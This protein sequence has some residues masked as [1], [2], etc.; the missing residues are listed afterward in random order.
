MIS[1]IENLFYTYKE[2][3]AIGGAIELFL[4][5]CHFSY[6]LA[7]TLCVSVIF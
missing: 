2:T 4:E 6:F 1:V 7:V 3:K 5:T